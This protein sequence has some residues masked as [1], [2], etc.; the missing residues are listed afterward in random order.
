MEKSAGMTGFKAARETHCRFWAANSA[1]RGFSDFFSEMDPRFQDL[2]TFGK[3]N[4]GSVAL[5][6]SLPVLVKGGKFGPLPRIFSNT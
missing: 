1:F 3:L 5:V 4:P 2:S 6:L